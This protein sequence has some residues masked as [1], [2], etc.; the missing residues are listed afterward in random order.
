MNSSRS[1][2]G[3]GSAARHP[4]LCLT[5]VS[6]LPRRE[7]AHCPS[8]ARGSGG[9]GTL[10]SSAAHSFPRDSDGRSSGAAAVH[11]PLRPAPLPV[12]APSC[13]VKGRWRGPGR[14]LSSGQVRSWR[15]RVAHIKLTWEELLESASV[16]Q[17]KRRLVQL[18]TGC[19][20]FPKIWLHPR[21]WHQLALNWV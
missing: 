7:A 8:P 15:K 19:K 20:L 6:R 16:K 2:R 5:W 13:P 14:P 3:N 12:P 9:R 17:K 18:G 10:S 1:V 11:S 4:R 21:A